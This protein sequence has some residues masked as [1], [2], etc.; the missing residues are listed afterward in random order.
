M[1]NR[2][3]RPIRRGAGRPARPTAALGACALAVLAATPLLNASTIRDD[4]PDG[5]YTALANDPKYASVGAISFTD[6]DHESFFA[7]GT[8]ISPY[9]VLTAAHVTQAISAATFNV[10][11]STG[12]NGTTYT[13]ADHFSHPNWPGALTTAG[14]D[15]GLIRLSSPVTDITPGSRYY[16]GNEL[17]Q[18]ATSVGFGL[19]GTGLTGQQANTLGTKRAIQNDIDAFGSAFGYQN[20]I[21]ASD[22]DDPNGNVTGP[23]GSTIT[24][25]L[26]GCIAGGDSGGAA[27]ISA[28]GRAY[29]AGVHSFFA[30][31]PF[32]G[33]PNGSYGDYYASTR[34]TQYNTWID[35]NLPN[36]WVG[37]S[38]GS[39]TDNSRWTIGTTTTNAYPT[40]YYT[41]G[42]NSPGSYTVT[43]D[44]SA[45]QNYQLLA[46]R[47]DITLNLNGST[48]S[49]VSQAYEG[50]LVVGR[51]SGN[52]ASIT[53]TGGTLNTRDAMLG[54]L[55]GS[56]GRIIMGANSTWNATGDVYVGGTS[57]GPGGGG[58]ITIANSTAA[59]NV[60][61]TL[62]VFTSGTVSYSNGTLSV[63][64]LDVAGGR[65]T[66]PTGSHRVLQARQLILSGLGKL[67]LNDNDMIIDYDGASPI[68]G[69]RS[70]IVAGFNN[71][72]QTG[73]GVIST[74]AKTSPNAGEAG[75]TR[76]GFG[77]ASS[78]GLTSFDGIN[79]DASTILLKYTYAGDANLDGMVDI[80]DLA[81]LASSWKT[82]GF[83][84]NGDFNYDGT[85]NAADLGL[86]SSNWQ[87]GATAALGPQLSLATTLTSL[88]LPT[89]VPEPTSIPLL[90]AATALLRRR[91][92][93]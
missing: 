55:T 11:G 88:G 38:S 32:M 44:G 76:V 53:L 70:Y 60:S 66:L 65:V 59:V 42:F 39:F 72:L 14:N 16:S 49:L 9:W 19:T 61:G 80:R 10:G 18:L 91:R 13:I 93:A 79:V 36:N 43:F 50:A 45:L 64:T 12:F 4:V 15:I 73:N 78:V 52:S 92:R 67:D 22:F 30:R 51:Y 25:A 46:R 35:D 31:D 5:S 71:G 3:V 57:V 74:R 81:L 2:S 41:A 17:G 89:A 62:R 21:F 82:S 75:K 40:A 54:Q 58:T 1:S 83:W 90:L 20:G 69:V 48:Y 28:N 23:L 34:V 84:T 56:S 24:R 8:L 63:G 29:V 37:N 6:A 47:G 86:L 26:E 27:F 85:V 7:S 87:A 77:E 68:S 33:Q